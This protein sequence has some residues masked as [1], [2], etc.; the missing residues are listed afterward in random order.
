MRAKQLPIPVPPKNKKN[1]LNVSSNKSIVLG[2]PLRSASA[3][4]EG[5]KNLDF[6]KPSGDLPVTATGTEGIDL[7]HL[8]TNPPYIDLTVP[9]DSGHLE[10]LGTLS[11]TDFRPL[12][13][14]LG[15]ISGKQ[16]LHKLLDFIRERTPDYDFFGF[17]MDLD[18][19]TSPDF[20]GEENVPP[21]NND[22]AEAETDLRVEEE[23]S[24]LDEVRKDC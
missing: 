2:S 23:P 16:A 21:L 12:R 1:A 18:A 6:A 9:E 15:S 10:A 22:G 24:A 7:Q 4:S 11:A 13:W 17:T 20:D 19:P 14:D 5:T 8:Q 3:S